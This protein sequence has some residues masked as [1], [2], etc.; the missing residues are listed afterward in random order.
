MEEPPLSAGA[1]QLRLICEADTVVAVSPVGA[2]GATARVVVEALLEGEP[3]PI[4][5]MVYT[6]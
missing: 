1:V 6:L 3:V 5:L 2:D 4:E